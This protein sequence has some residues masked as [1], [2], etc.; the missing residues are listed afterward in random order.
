MA[1]YYPDQSI[2][3]PLTTIRRER[4]LPPDAV[5][6]S[7]MVSEGQR[8]NE[9]D[10][11]ARGVRSSRFVI[12]DLFRLL[13]IKTMSR[14]NEMLLV[15]RTD[16]VRKGQAIAGHQEDRGQQVRS[17]VTG[18]VSEI[19]DDGRLILQT[20][21]AEIEVKTGFRGVVASIRG[22]RGALL[23]TV[24]G[25]VQGVWGNGQ[26]NLGVLHMEPERG[27]SSLVVDEF[28]TEWRG[29]VVVS[30]QPLDVVALKK[31]NA[32]ALG[33]I[34]APSMPAD[35]RGIALKLKIPI[36]LTEGFGNEHMSQIAVSVLES[37]VERQ[38][39]LNA[40]RPNRWLPDRPEVIIPTVAEGNPLAPALNEPLRVG[41]EVRITRKPYLGM[42]ARVKSLP[43]MPQM[44]DNGLR[45]PVA[46]V[47]L[48]SGRAV[49]VPLVNLEL[50]GRG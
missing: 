33:G 26:T 38:A 46:E 42:V 31:A 9:Y 17:P 37:Y 6:T 35:L 50:F 27:L 36:I 11:V 21:L 30:T 2:I 5:S 47:T 23:E 7:I 20:D 32:Q 48:P 14:L 22:N 34:I 19:L 41:A 40:R 15:D 8:V 4:L 29:A 28:S 25:L 39:T 24:G 1:I 3:L 18:V 44:I 43:R 45:L 16:P 13:G 12:L 49:T 10:V